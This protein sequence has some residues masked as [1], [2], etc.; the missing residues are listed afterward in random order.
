MN[1]PMLVTGRLELSLPGPDDVFA[2]AE[3]VAHPVTGKYLGATQSRADAFAR[4]L[5][6]A[7]SWQVYGYGGFMVR[8]KGEPAVIGNIGVFHSYRGLG[9]DFDDKPEAGWILA[10]DQVGKGLA[11]EAMRAVLAWFDAKHGPREIVCMIDPD[12]AASI[13]LAE[14]LGFAATRRAVLP[15]GADVQLFN[16]SAL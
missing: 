10:H 1:G 11:G 15:D 13:A 5:R 8:L 3:I 6:N 16:R 2:M 7:G 4:F 12:N 9:A 14:R